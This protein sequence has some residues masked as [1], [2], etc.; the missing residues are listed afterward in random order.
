M[1]ETNGKNK[2]A[3]PLIE[4][5]SPSNYNISAFM[6]PALGLRAIPD[7][8][9]WC[10]QQ[11]RFNPAYAMA[12]FEDMEMKDTTIASALEAR[13][14]NVLSKDRYFVAASDK[15][16]DQKISDHLEET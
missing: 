1:A 5:L 14:R 10:W 9:T 13:K 11:I 7:D 15:K 2:E 4:L 12:I 16:R 8:P 6:T 3:A